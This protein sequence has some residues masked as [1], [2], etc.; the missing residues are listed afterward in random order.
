[1]DYTYWYFG[2]AI[3]FDWLFLVITV[4]VVLVNVFVIVNV[5]IQ[6]KFAFDV[7]HYWVFVHVVQIQ[8]L[9]YRTISVV[10]LTVSPSQIFVNFVINFEVQLLVSFLTLNVDALVVI[11]FSL[12][13]QIFEL[14]APEFHYFFLREPIVAWFAALAAHCKA[15]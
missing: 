5:Y 6:I 15:K 9:N 3:G 2:L 8:I 12:C 14:R 4:L 7:V 13:R 10:A 1:M 11:H